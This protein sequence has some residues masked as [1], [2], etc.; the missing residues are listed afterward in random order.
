[1]ERQKSCNLVQELPVVIIGAGP[2][3]LAAAAQLALRKVPFVVLEAGAGVAANIRNW[4]HVRLFT[5][6]GNNIDA[7]AKQLLE[8]QGWELPPVTELP[9]GAD[10]ISK[11][12][13]PL[14]EVPEIKSS[15]RY[16]AK[17]ISIAKKNQDKMKSANREQV[18]F[19]IYIHGEENNSRLEARA[20]IDATGTWSN[21]NPIHTEGVWLQDEQLLQD[22]IIYGVPNFEKDSIVF[23]G[24]HVAVVGS[25]HSALNTLYELAQIKKTDAATSITWILRKDVA[26]TYGLQEKDSIEARGSLG[27][28]I[29]K[30]AEA[31]V[32]QI[33]TP[34]YI[35]ETFERD[36]KVVIRGEL[37]G[38]EEELV[39]DKIIA[40]TGNRPNFEFLK[41]LR[42]HNDPITESNH[43]IASLIDPNKH[44]CGS[45][46]LHGEQQ[47]RHPEKDFY[48]VGMK[49]YGRAPTFLL[50]TG[51]EQVRS[52]SAYLSGGIEESKRTNQECKPTTCG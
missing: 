35:H 45:V 29:R 4:Q 30:L 17:V 31:G 9:T 36:E 38:R 14:S 8:R 40:N 10:L 7:D 23:K 52:I 39:V 11:Y 49:S 46:P 26:L 34:F 13:E 3:G 51:Y 37:L 15:I 5:T 50:A 42:L 21:P 22:E 16:N 43:H 24:K 41:E 2:I 18:P 20:V 44:S 33:K 47:L 27:V 12:L 25:G 32:I 28:N 6:W 1:M 48:I 19:V